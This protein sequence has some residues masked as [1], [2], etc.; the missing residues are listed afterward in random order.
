MDNLFK[1]LPEVLQW[2]ILTEFVGSHVVRYK[3]LRRKFTGA[4]HAT[5][6]KNY[7]TKPPKT[8]PPILDF[9][10][11]NYY[12]SRYDMIYFLV[13]GAN[14]KRDWYLTQPDITLDPYVKHTL[15]SYPYTDKKLGRRPLSKVTFY[16][17]NSYD[18][19]I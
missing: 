10:Y 8:K 16:R 9:R 2:E 6:M 15:P 11:L 12:T 19:N 13:R 7:K 4:I 3:K 18:K 1:A 5:L 14:K 17:P